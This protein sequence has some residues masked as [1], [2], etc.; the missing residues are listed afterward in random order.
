MK[1]LIRAN[2]YPTDYQDDWELVE[3]KPVLDYDGFHTDY[4]LWHNILTDE[5]VTIFGDIDLYDPTNESPD[6]EFETEAEAVEW[7]DN[8]NGF[9]DD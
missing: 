5:W 2:H 8:Y 3:T 4:S 9:E 6:A 7:F 1:K